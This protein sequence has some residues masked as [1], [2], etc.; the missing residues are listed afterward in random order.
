MFSTITGL[1]KN[2]AFRTLADQSREI[3]MMEEFNSDPKRAEKFTLK[4][5]NS[6]GGL[7]LYFDFSKNIIDDSKFKQLIDI[8]RQANVEQWRDKMFS[9]E[10]I[11][12]TEGRSV[13]HVALRNRENKPIL[14]DGKDVMPD[15]NA[16]LKHMK[17]FCDQIIS[18]Q[19]TGYT[20]E[21]ITDVVNIGIGGSDLGPLMVT[22]ALKYYQKGPN[23]HFVSNIDGTHLAESIPRPFFSSLL[24]KRLQTITNAESAREWFVTKAGD[25]KHVAKHFVALSTNATKVKEFGISEENMFEFWDWV[26]GR[27]SLWSAIGLSIAVHI[28]FENFE[29]LLDGAFLVDKH[30]CQ[31]PLESNIPV[32]L[33]V[34]GILYIN[35]HKAETLALCFMI[36]ICIVLLPISNKEIWKVMEKVNGSGTLLQTG[37]IVWGEPGTNGQHAFYQLIHQ[38]KH[39]IP[40]DFIAP[41]QSLNPI[42][43]G[44]HHTILL[45][46]FLAQ[47]EAL[48][49]GKTS[50][51]V[52][53][54][55]KQSGMDETKIKE[56]LPHKVFE[57]NRPS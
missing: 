4:L 17:E 31:T 45:A 33:A 32:V 13:L 51:E 39:L 24:Q 34:L 7:Q 18:G 40:C 28:G 48:M 2:G 43:G 20:G 27:Y 54:E 3:N 56:I 12:F 55:L 46:N 16:V 1:V 29:Q 42:S 36:S 57:G 15:V 35:L 11:N 23:V 37:P 30:F 44:R 53:S 52:E 8:A 10:H 49:K 47:T 9:G 26:G 50:E 14:V 19:W 6:N 25:A 38:G 22:E 5:L 21:K 41:I